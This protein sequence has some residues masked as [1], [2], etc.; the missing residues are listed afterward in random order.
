M[1]LKRSPDAAEAEDHVSRGVAA[2]SAIAAPFFV[3]LVCLVGTSS[4]TEDF[5][6]VRPVF[7]ILASLL[8]GVAALMTSVMVQTLTR[9]STL[10]R[11]SPAPLGA[12][13]ILATGGLVV[14]VYV[15]VAA[16]PGGPVFHDSWGELIAAVLG[17]W[18]GLAALRLLDEHLMWRFV[19]AAS[20]ALVAAS[21]AIAAL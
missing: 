15:F 4:L 19:G 16:A 21:V 13:R 2:A 17:L 18:V 5:E 6:G 9:S 8:L 20:V 11:L 7:A 14:S 12:L 3:L 10:A 1:L